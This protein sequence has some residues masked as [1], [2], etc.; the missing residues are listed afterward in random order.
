MLK[1]KI[2][3]IIF[4]ILIYTIF[5]IIFGFLY[6]KLDID[7]IDNIGFSTICTQEQLES[8]EY[9][10]KNKNSNRYYFVPPKKHVKIK[11]TLMDYILFSFTTTS[12]VGYRSILNNSIPVLIINIIHLILIIAIIPIIIYI[13]K[14]N[15][16]DFIIY[17]L[18]QLIF[19]IIFTIL[20]NLVNSYDKKNSSPDDEFVFSYEDLMDIYID[21]IQR[22]D[23]D[24]SKL[25]FKANDDLW[26][27]KSRDSWLES[28]YFS[29]VT[30]SQ[31]GYGTI[32]PKTKLMKFFNSIQH[33]IILILIIWFSFK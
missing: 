25:I 6:Y 32:Y 14:G 20:Y 30:Q 13:I 2:I 33:I 27:V 22:K 16:K 9:K 18:T 5:T 23:A 31:V 4:I 10:K 8:I 7:S 26:T 17:I 1:K 29:V 15:F 24:G 11:S 28:L 3:F 21:E 12:T 19:V